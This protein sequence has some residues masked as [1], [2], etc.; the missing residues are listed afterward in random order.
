M[1]LPRPGGGGGEIGVAR[2]WRGGGAGVAEGTLRTFR[3]YHLFRKHDPAT[4][5][6]GE[7]IKN[8]K[9]TSIDYFKHKSFKRG[10]DMFS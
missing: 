9:N 5:A 3:L 4:S 7:K 1:T 2:G 8:K 10:G 6:R